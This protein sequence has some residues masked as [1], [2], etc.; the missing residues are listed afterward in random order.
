MKQRAYHVVNLDNEVLYTVHARSLDHAYVKL[1]VLFRP[2]E[3]GEDVFAHD[4]WRDEQRLIREQLA[5]VQHPEM[6][7]ADKCFGF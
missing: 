5:D 3:E 4:E 7:G 2:L 6:T 1:G